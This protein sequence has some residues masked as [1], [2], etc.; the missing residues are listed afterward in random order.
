MNVPLRPYQTAAAD[1]TMQLWSAGVPSCLVELPTGTGKTRLA[2]ELIGHA[3]ADG[4]RALFLAHRLTLVKQGAKEIGRFLDRR[5]GVW[6]GEE[7]SSLGAQIL[8][9]SKDTLHHANLNELDAST[10]SCMVIDEAHHCSKNNQ[11]YQRVVNWA[12]EGGLKLLGITATPDRSD[13]VTLIGDGKP[14]AELAYRYPIWDCEGGASAINDGWLVPVRQEHVHIDG[15]DF[16]PIKKKRNWTDDDIATVLAKEELQLRLASATIQTAEHRQTVVFCPTVAFAYKMG[17]L[18][19]RYAERAASVVIH[20]QHPEFPLTRDERHKRDQ[21]YKSGERQFAVSVDALTEGWDAPKTSCVVVMRPVKSRLR[22]AQQVGRGTR[23]VLDIPNERLLEMSAEERR[24]AIAASKKPDCMVVGFQSNLADLKLWVNV[25]DILGEGME[26]E[27]RER[28]KRLKEGDTTSRLLTA[29]AQLDAEKDFHAW[30]IEQRY[31]SEAERLKMFTPRAMIRRTS[32]NLYGKGSVDPYALG[33]D[34]SE[35]R[36]M[37]ITPDV[38]AGQRASVKAA[39]LAVGFG[40][41]P[42]FA[43]K[44]TGNQIRGFIGRA[45]DSGAAVNWKLVNNAERSVNGW[46]FTDGGRANRD[47]GSS[48]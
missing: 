19:D 33:L 24:A 5:V 2:A 32:V 23:L 4:K 3:T 45:K 6:S 30:E 31:A 21:L 26:P 27:V 10:F 39:R 18:I 17:E 44:M 11:S 38:S 36:A 9:A 15:L 1:A 48:K 29:K 46:F 28:A 37:R 14:F 8:S 20:G 47:G 12:K 34:K 7:Q 25:E 40:L 35:Q 13:G 43:M 16:S 42:S 22:F 41:D